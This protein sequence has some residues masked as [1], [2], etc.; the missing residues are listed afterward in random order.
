MTEVSL[1]HTLGFKIVQSKLYTPTSSVIHLHKLSFT[2]S[3][4]QF[5]LTRMLRDDSNAYNQAIM[6]DIKSFNSNL[7][8]GDQ[9]QQA[10]RS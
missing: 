7:V 8:L 3:I 5:F 1:L 10:P 4:N 9:N 6:V 2:I